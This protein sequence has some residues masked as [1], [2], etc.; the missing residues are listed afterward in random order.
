MPTRFETIKSPRKRI[1]SIKKN[2]ILIFGQ[3]NLP[4]TFPTSIPIPIDTFQ[5]DIR[6]DYV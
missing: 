1:K 2:S 3:K 6:S 4:V 5:F